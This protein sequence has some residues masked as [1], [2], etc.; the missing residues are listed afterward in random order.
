MVSEPTH[1]QNEKIWTETITNKLCTESR[2]E[3]IL[4]KSGDEKYSAIEILQWKA[5][6]QEFAKIIKQ[7]CYL[8]KKKKM[9]QEIRA[10][11]QIRCKDLQNN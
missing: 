3:K 11:I 5:Q 6:V 4:Q 7:K 8:E 1:L 10:A 2:L 9:N